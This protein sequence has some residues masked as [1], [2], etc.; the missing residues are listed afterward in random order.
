[1]ISQSVRKTLPLLKTISKL[2]KANRNKVLSELG[3]EDVIYKALREIAHNTIKG[4]VKLDNSQKAKLK[5]HTKTLRSLC[6][7]NKC[8]KRR[9]KLIIQSGG[10]LPI[11][12]PAVASLIS[13]LIAKNV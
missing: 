6:T 2:S 11:L 13:S 9:K 5:P 3:G 4:N 7:S 1:M 8:L 10:F 12:I